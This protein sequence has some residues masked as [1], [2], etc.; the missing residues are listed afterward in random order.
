MSGSL[1]SLPPVSINFAHRMSRHLKQF[2]IRRNGPIY[3]RA[4]TAVGEIIDT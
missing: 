1:K 2:L 3:E 4:L